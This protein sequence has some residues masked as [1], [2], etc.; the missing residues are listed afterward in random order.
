LDWH[1]LARAFAL[2][3]VLEGVMPFLVPARWRQTMLTIAGMDSRMIRI[4]GLMSMLSGL[5]VLKLAT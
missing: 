2:V 1:E 5:V 4:I 3:M